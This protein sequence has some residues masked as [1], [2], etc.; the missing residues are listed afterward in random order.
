MNILIEHWH[1]DPID[2]DFRIERVAFL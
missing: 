1:F 2:T